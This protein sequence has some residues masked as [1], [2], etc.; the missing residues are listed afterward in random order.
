MSGSRKSESAARFAANLWE[1]AR[2][3]RPIEAMTADVDGFAEALD[4]APEALAQALSLAETVQG[5]LASV[6]IAS[7][8]SAA[9]DRTGG[10]VIADAAFGAWRI[11]PQAL[12][13]VTRDLPQGQPRL[14]VVV[15][16]ADGRPI[17]IA[18][19]RAQ[20]ALGWPLAPEVRA[21]L[22]GG[23]AAFA[24]L[25]VRPSATVWSEIA[26]AYGLTGLETRVA[27]ALVDQG[28]LRRAAAAAGV[29]Y[30][31][32]REALAGVMT[33]TSSRRQAELIQRLTLLAIG[34]V[35]AVE[36][37]WRTF[38]DMFDLTARQGRLAWSVAQGAT[39]SEAARA[40]GVSEHAAKTD[41]GAVF[42]ACG[43]ATAADLGRLAA[44]VDA[45]A[46]LA[47]AT[48]IQWSRPGAQRAP[49]RFVRRRRAPG[50]I[51]V[52]D[53]GPLGAVPVVV[54]HTP[55]NGRHLPRNL[56][57]ALHDRGLRPISVERPGYGL[58]TPTHADGNLLDEASDDLIDVLDAL[59]LDRVRLLGRGCIAALAFA[60][61]HPARFERG[62][63]LGPS[64]PDPAQRRRDG[65]LGA[66]GTL[67]LERPALVD[68]FVTMLIRGSTTANIE[69]MTRAAARHSPADLAALADPAIFADHVRSTQQAALGGIGF[70]RE[71]AIFAGR[72]G[73]QLDQPGERWRIIIG[74]RDP[75]HQLG[76]PQAAW[77]RM[78]PGARVQVLQGAGRFP[79]FTHPAEIAAALA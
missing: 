10:V 41:L 17:A 29:A 12:Q 24:V 52:E 26:T 47:A 68:A 31:T 66:I 55:T 1:A 19:A 62:I 11:A 73:P 32:A 30:E 58:T 2:V 38:A 37:G 4:H 75:L 35:T 14:A 27:T 33:K 5:G 39:R 57:A 44:E 46:G 56:V 72:A 49:L 22:D 67:I 50:R 9:C 61:R 54:I 23:Q 74:D 60:A 76:D 7:F 13:D 8:A 59:G 51:A 79:H 64:A 40:A 69:R 15:D 34:Q 70:A 53:H 36:D 42:A 78:L 71:L 3:R 20:D 21:A 65:L 28:D 63:L 25:A 18:L 48:D 16:D 43:V 77:R 45:L 6:R